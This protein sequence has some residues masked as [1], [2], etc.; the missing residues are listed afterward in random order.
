MQVSYNQNETWA[1]CSRVDDNKIKSNESGQTNEFKFDY[2]HQFISDSC[3]R[4]KITAGW[5]TTT[6]RRL[7]IVPDYCAVKACR[8]GVE[9]S[10]ER[11]MVCVELYIDN[12]T[13]YAIVGLMHWNM[14]WY[15]AFIIL[16]V[17][18]QYFATIG[19]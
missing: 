10:D 8:H 11:S 6:K 1:D 3:C 2:H 15:R 5:L 14:M 13:A 12:K 9:V 19:L 16:T 7:F 4:I 17:A 18:V